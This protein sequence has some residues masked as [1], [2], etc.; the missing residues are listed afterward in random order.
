MATVIL[1]CKTPSGF[2]MELD[3]RS[4]VING[5]QNQD[6]GVIIVERGHQIGITHEVDKSLWDAW[7][8]KFAN[9]PLVKNGFVF[10]AKSENSAKAQAKEMKEVKTGLEQKTKAELEKVAGAKESKDQP[11]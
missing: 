4:H 5:A 8:K 7:R 3:G 9:H 11:E 1:G 2:T 10:E 6:G